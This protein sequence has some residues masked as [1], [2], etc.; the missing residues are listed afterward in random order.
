MTKSLRAI[1]LAAGE[2]IRLRPYTLDRPK[3]LV[4]LGGKPL[5]VYQIEVLESLGIYDITVVTGYHADRIEA[6]GFKTIHNP[7]YASTNMVASLMCAAELLDG[8][9]D[10]LIAYGDIIYEPRVVQ[11]LLECQAPICTTVDKSW[12]RLWQTRSED[13]L[14]DAETLRLSES[15]DILEL[16]EKP[17]T[18]KKIEGQYM[19]LIKVK[20]EF[21]PQLAVFY[22]QMDQ[23]SLFDGKNFPN[24][25]MTSF[26]QY[27]IDSGQ[28]V[29]AVLV[30]G[31]WLEID[32]AEDLELFNRMHREGSLSD[33]CRI[34]P[35]KKG[36]VSGL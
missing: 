16:G 33:Y 2:G 29:R 9:A 35:E 31:G 26:L 7:H 13:P 18:L 27:L 11:A 24:M 22:R 30:S 23:N 21:A 10:I 14:A 34:S 36:T 12:L 6:L 28:S 8:K 25:F 3:C 15:Q 1:I 32:T 19:G 5:I 20:A 17:E 4:E